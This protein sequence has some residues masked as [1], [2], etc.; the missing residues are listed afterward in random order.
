ME[1]R[2]KRILKTVIFIFGT[3][4]VALGIAGMFLP[5]LPTTPFLLLAAFC[6]TK[7]SKRMHEALLNNRWCGNYIRNYREGNGIILKH[8]IFT[9]VLL[10]L[11]I[12]YTVTFIIS[13]IWL[14]LLLLAIAIGVTIHIVKLKTYKINKGEN[15][16]EV[17]FIE[18]ERIL[19]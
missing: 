9:L 7:S 6:Y 16:D 19:K 1:G 10:W 5:L 15:K 14:K 12:G 2:I 3:M 11:T 18:I 13:T 4:S 8:K 17:E